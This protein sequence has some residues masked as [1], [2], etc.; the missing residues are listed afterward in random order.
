MRQRFLRVV[1]AMDRR[2]VLAVM[3]FV[4]LLACIEAWFL[5]LRAPFGELRGQTALRGELAAQAAIADAAAGIRRIE[6]ELAQLER[7][8]QGDRT[9]PR[10]D[11]AILMLMESLGRFAASHDVTLGRVK[12][13][14]R[15]IVRGFEESG[16]DIEAR[17]EY[18]KLHSWLH[19]IRTGLAPMVVTA[20]TLNS[21]DQGPRVVLT[22]KLAD[23]RPVT[24]GKDMQ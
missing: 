16:F 1:A 18:R 14:G 2:L 15:R 10:E 4:V 21:T 7:Q 6:A 3:A 23:Y 11:A 5:V 24:G 9:A 19:A 22:L 8:L 20:F 17:G 12:P 13:G